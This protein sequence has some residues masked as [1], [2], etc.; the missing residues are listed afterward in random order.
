MKFNCTMRKRL[1]HKKISLL[2]YLLLIFYNDQVLL[3]FLLILSNL[4]FKNCF[5][6]AILL[7]VTRRCIFGRFQRFGLSAFSITRFVTK[8]RT[9]SALSKPCNFLIL[10]ALFGPNLFGRFLSVKP[11]KSPSP[12]LIMTKLKTEISGPTSQPR[13]DLRL[14]SPLRRGL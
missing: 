10:E 9:S 11:S 4:I 12:L 1:L 2:F 8:S 13:T 3:F 14:R 5:F 6:L 7:G